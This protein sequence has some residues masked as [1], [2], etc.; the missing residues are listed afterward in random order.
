[1][2]SLIGPV[3]HRRSGSSRKYKTYLIQ[4]VSGRH[5]SCIIPS[6]HACLVATEVHPLLRLLASSYFDICC[7]SW[8]LSSPRGGLIQDGEVVVRLDLSTYLLLCIRVVRGADQEPES[9]GR[10]HASARVSGTSFLW[11]HVERRGLR[12]AW[13]RS[14]PLRAP[15]P[16][17]R[18]AR[19][20]HSP[21]RGARRARSLVRARARVV[22]LSLWASQTYKSFWCFVTSWL[23]VPFTGGKVQYT[24]W[25]IVSALFWVPAG[26]AAVIAVEHSG[27]ALSQVEGRRRTSL[28]VTPRCPNLHYR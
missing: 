17:F 22:V 24:P 12:V 23:V 16:P 20:A 14:A 3:T 1:M 10:R 15:L 5:A 19:G 2:K 26:V 18:A 25:G 27:L 9:S 7:D 11:L 6:F 21:R 13:G 4:I 28:R 8:S